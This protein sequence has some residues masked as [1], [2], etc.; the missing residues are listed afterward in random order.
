MTPPIN[1]PQK[2]SSPKKSHQWAWFIALWCGGLAAALT[3][4][5]VIKLLMSFIK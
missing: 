5:G 3:L 1:P 2:K 4:G